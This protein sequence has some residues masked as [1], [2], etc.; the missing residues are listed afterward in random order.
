MTSYQGH[1]ELRHLRYFVAVATDGTFRRAAGRLHVSQPALSK[2]I[3]NLERE[4]GGALFSR[5]RK[6]IQLTPTG[7][8]FLTRAQDLL[9]M[10]E[11]AAK[12]AREAHRNNLGLLRVGRLGILASNF[13]PSVLEVY[14]SHFPAVDVQLFEMDQGEQMS[15]LADGRIDVALIALK[16][17]NFPDWFGHKIVL[18]AKFQ[19]GM[20]RQHRLANQDS[21]SLAD[22][23]GEKFFYYQPPG[24]CSGHRDRTIMTFEWLG[25]PVPTLE[26][27]HDHASIEALVVAGHGVTLVQPRATLVANR[28]SVILPIKEEVPSLVLSIAAGWN[29]GFPQESV[30]RFVEMLEQ[31]LRA[32]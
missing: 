32:V 16:E 22:L 4:L 11:G 1:M 8:M 13:L 25:L 29:V 27:A 6:G 12:Q 23:T 15:A 17:R 9:E 5:G 10:A 19:I 18:E 2:Q 30:M 14:R 20:N 26:P 28:E 21:I 3:Q 24:G 7:E 31:T